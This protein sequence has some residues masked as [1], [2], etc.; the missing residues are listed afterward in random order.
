VNTYRIKPL[1]L[2]IIEIDK[3]LLTYRFNYGKTIR[4]PNFVWYI[5][6]SD[7]NI[8]VD[9]AADAKLAT[10]F[11]GFPAEEIISFEEGLAGFGLTPLDIDIVIQTH[12]HWDHC[13]N[14]GKC[15]NAEIIVQEEELRFA[16]DPHPIAAAAYNKDLLADLNFTTVKGPY[17]VLPG[18][19]LIPTPGHTPGCQSV[20]VAT[21]K[22]KAIITGFC[23]SNENFAPPEGAS[24]KVR[25]LM[26]V[27]TPGIHLNAV[28]AFAS[29][30]YVKENAD[31]IIP[32]HEPSFM[33]VKSIP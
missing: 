21:A 28:D 7:K 6:G 24:Q 22:G 10:E 20:A 16:F 19:N 26:P 8:L 5:E 25:D 30:L 2:S 11:R 31:I 32:H 15:K 33:G 14:T 29:A 1:P 27:I 4:V 12:L 23:C 18:I 9:T 3:G 13:G 17:E